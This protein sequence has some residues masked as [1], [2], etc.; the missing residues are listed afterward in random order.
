MARVDTSKY[1]TFPQITERLDD[2]VSQV[3]D[4]D[5]SLERSLDLFDEAIA[6]GTRAVD[7]VDKA[8]FSPEERERLA[9]PVSAQDADEGE[10]AT[11]EFEAKDAAEHAGADSADEAK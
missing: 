4:K 1:Q 5:V 11:G 10:K 3:R 7:L 2:I 8:A 9:E 6:L